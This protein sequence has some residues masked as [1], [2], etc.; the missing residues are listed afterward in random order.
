[1]SEQIYSVPGQTEGR[2]RLF[3]GC[4]RIH[5][6]YDLLHVGVMLTIIKV[7]IILS[8]LI[9]IENILAIFKINQL[10][11]LLNWLSRYILFLTKLNGRGRLKY[12][13]M[14]GGEYETF[15][16]ELLS[17]ISVVVSASNVDEH[18]FG[19]VI[20]EDFGC[21]GSLFISKLLW[22]I[23]LLSKLTSLQ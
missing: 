13:T 10:A 18:L 3:L 6:S 9:R 11:L 16:L 2:R 20:W 23:T 22:Q 14:N 15:F 5:L 1:M 4:K 21:F 19:I 8:L 17:V 12:G 7:F